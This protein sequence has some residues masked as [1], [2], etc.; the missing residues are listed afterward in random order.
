MISIIRIADVLG[1]TLPVAIAICTIK[2]SALIIYQDA[3]RC[4]KLSLCFSRIENR[5]NACRNL[6]AAK[7]KNAIALHLIKLIKETQM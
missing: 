6:P 4:S 3:L 7:E 1:V 5:N 2:E